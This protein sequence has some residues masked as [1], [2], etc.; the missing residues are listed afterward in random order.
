M[1]IILTII[2]YGILFIVGFILINLLITTVCLFLT[3]KI[4]GSINDEWSS[5]L[6]L[7]GYSI[8]VGMLF[9]FLNLILTTFLSGHT[10]S[11]TLVI[12]FITNILALIKITDIVYDLGWL[13]SVL[14]ILVA[15]LMNMIFIILLFFITTFFLSGRQTLKLSGVQP[16]EEVDGT[17]I[18]RPCGDFSFCGTGGICLASGECI[19]EKMLETEYETGECDSISCENCEKGV[20]SRGYTVLGNNE[21]NYCI[22]CNPF[23]NNYCLEGYS[24]FTGKCIPYDPDNPKG[25][26]KCEQESCQNC[27]SGRL[28]SRWD[29]NDDGITVIECYDCDSKNKCNSGYECESNVCIKTEN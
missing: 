17:E 21:T 3:A 12:L 23:D 19:S 25:A 22:E 24:C 5:A 2:S 14:Y 18:G 16:E 27:E 15:S 8:L 26:I 10:L 1:E 28:N 11:V 9:G 6:R 7:L 4:F 13:K 29:V 20:K